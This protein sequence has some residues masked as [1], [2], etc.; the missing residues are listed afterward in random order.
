MQA[1]HKLGCWPEGVWRANRAAMMP[2]GQLMHVTCGPG[3][4]FLLRTLCNERERVHTFEL[5]DRGRACPAF[6]IADLLLHGRLRT[7]R[8]S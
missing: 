1:L 7:V 2:R 6:A 5:Q 8:C 3:G 4:R